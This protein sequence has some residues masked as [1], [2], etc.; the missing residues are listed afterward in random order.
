M[1]R[2][3]LVSACVSVIQAVLILIIT[4]SLTSALI[5]CIA[6]EE[7]DIIARIANAGEQINSI[8]HHRC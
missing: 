7:D 6:D 8:G 1:R 2:S 3:M 5:A 4:S